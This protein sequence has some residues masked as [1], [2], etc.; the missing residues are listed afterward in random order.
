M[1]SLGLVLVLVLVNMHDPFMSC[2][3]CHLDLIIWT[4]EPSVCQVALV[5]T[6]QLDF[7]TTLIVTGCYNILSGL[8]FGIPMCVQPMKTIAAV[9]LTSAGGRNQAIGL[10]YPYEKG[11]IRVLARWWCAGGSA[12]GVKRPCFM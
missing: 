7:G 12:D 4:S 1:S 10:G 11:S 6:I 9:A 5:P 2:D 3:S 8:A